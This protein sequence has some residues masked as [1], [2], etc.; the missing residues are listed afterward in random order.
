MWDERSERRGTKTSA[1]RRYKAHVNVQAVLCGSIRASV[2]FP[3]VCGLLTLIDERWTYV[4]R[5]L[6]SETLNDD[7]R[8]HVR[9][10]QG[11]RERTG[12]GGGGDSG[13]GG[14]GRVYGG[15]GTGWELGG[16]ERERENSVVTKVERVVRA[17]Q[18]TDKVVLVCLTCRLP[19][20]T[21]GTFSLSAPPPPHHASV[22]SLSLLHNNDSMDVY[23]EDSQTKRGR[24]CVCVC[25]GG[26]GG[27]RDVVR[28]PVRNVRCLIHFFRSQ[29]LPG[30]RPSRPTCRQ[31]ER[32]ATTALPV[33]NEPH[34]GTFFSHTQKALTLC[35][36]R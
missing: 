8:C 30:Y 23:H 36:A 34:S 12:G 27:L 3:A 18:W 31:W 13:G 1:H 4:F 14:V 29:H 22:G 16:R 35:A 2:V 21:L 15:G 19:S 7:R 17:G 6:C 25:V 10:R 5:F 32:V 24:V 9:A 20:A 28:K 11:G 26:G 33:P